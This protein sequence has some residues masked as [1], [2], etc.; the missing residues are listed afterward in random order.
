MVHSLTEGIQAAFASQAAVIIETTKFMME[1]KQETSK[2]YIKKVTGMA[3]AAG[4]K[5]SVHVCLCVGVCFCVCLNFA[6]FVLHANRQP[7]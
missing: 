5:V 1:L 4:C 3:H 2:E 6:K 7:Y